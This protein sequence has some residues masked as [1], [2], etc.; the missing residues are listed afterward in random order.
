MALNKQWT[1]E[2]FENLMKNLERLRDYE[3]YALNN[4]QTVDTCAH[5]Q[6]RSCKGTGVKADG[7]MCIHALSCSCS[8]CRTYC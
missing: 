1:F 2:D 7:Q 6:C 5:T 3:K 4:F 8:R